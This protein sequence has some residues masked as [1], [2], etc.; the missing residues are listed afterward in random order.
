M[1]TRT[2]YVIG[3]GAMLVVVASLTACGGSTKPAAS[4]TS[5]AASASASPPAAAGGGNFLQSTQVQACLKAAGISIPT[6]SGTRP[7]GSFPSGTRPTGER[8][9]G[10]PSGG[11]GAGGAGGGFGAESTE[12]QAALK[13]CGITLPTG[14][15]GAPTGTAPSSAPTS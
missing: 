7:T 2:H 4:A 12:I 8:P 15:R 5:A 6:R 14:G 11:A 10:T 9:T 13:A 3:I 1:A